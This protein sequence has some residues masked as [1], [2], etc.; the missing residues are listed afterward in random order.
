MRVNIADAGGVRVN[1]VPCVYT[2]ITLIAFFIFFRVNIAV[3]VYICNMQTCITVQ[4]CMSVPPMPVI[5]VF[6]LYLI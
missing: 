3:E 5:A 2:K 1:C 6:I 4:V